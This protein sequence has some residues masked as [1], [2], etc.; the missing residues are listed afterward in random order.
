M[1]QRAAATAG[2]LVIRSEMRAGRCH[3]VGRWLKHRDQRRPAFFHA[4]VDYIAG[5]RKRY[6]YLALG[7][8]GNAIA[9]SAEPGDFKFL[10]AHD[11]TPPMRNSWLPSLPS[12][13]EAIGPTAR[14][15]GCSLSHSA[16]F[17]ATIGP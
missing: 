13:G 6:E 16:R 17:S 4:G 9:L 15:P 2:V 11:L 14:H 10:S 3:P 5:H 8:L 12:I 7:R 1:L